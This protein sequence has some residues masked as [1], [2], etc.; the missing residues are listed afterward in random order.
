[1][2]F[3]KNTAY[4]EN[5][6]KLNLSQTLRHFKVATHMHISLMTVDGEFTKQK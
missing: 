6:L 1:M 3:L 5:R 4:F 2:H